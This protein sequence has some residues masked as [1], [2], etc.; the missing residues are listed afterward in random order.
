MAPIKALF[1]FRALAEGT[2]LLTGF[3]QPLLGDRLFATGYIGSNSAHKQAWLLI[4][5]SKVRSIASQI[6]LADID[7]IQQYLTFVVVIAL[8]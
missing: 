1:V 6:I 3:S 5:H 4:H 7:T 2:R 8:E